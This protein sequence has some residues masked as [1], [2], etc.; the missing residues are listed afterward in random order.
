[1]ADVQ[2][3][4]GLTVFSRDRYISSYRADSAPYLHPEGHPPGEPETA[5]TAGDDGAYHADTEAD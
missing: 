2:E 5:P 4:T 3:F 1:M